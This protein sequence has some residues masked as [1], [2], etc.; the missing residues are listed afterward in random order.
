MA[1]LFV[2]EYPWF[3]KPAIVHKILISGADIFSGA[4]C[5]LGNCPRKPR[6]LE[7]RLVSTSEVICKKYLGH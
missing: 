2:K 7:R 1:E 3:C 6:N 5:L 4:F